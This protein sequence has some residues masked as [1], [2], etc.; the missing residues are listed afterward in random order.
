MAINP[1]EEYEDLEYLI[2][3]NYYDETNPYEMIDVKNY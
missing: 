2:N 3:Y 1:K